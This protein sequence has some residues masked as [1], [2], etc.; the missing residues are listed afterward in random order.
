[1]S[2]RPI[3][4]CRYCHQPVGEAHWQLFQHVTCQPPIREEVMAAE[5]DADTIG[6][7]ARE[8]LSRVQETLQAF[9][10]RDQP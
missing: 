2:W 10:R 8:T 9:V 3:P 6:R 7:R 5:G 1:M 4:T